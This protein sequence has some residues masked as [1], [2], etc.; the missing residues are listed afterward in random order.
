MND[1][2]FDD[3]ATTREEIL[4]ATYR[5][6]RRHGYADLT[7]QKIG[8]ELE[9]SPSLIY[10]HY[11]DK[12][13]LV[14]ACLEY[15]LDHFEDELGRGS[16]EDPR[17]RLE[18]LLDWGFGSA[19]SDEWQAFMQTVL[20]LRV[21]AIHDAAYREHFTR[22]DRVFTES[23]A[24][25]IRAGVASGEFR[26][27]DPAA[28]AEMLQLLYF[29]R[30]LRLASTADDLEEWAADVQLEIQKYLETRVYA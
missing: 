4:A 28:V 1:D 30:A 29:G 19:M 3:P 8:D 6:L 27:C 26:D 18:G 10:H 21:Q 25:I 12:D 7:I 16:I 5:S 11:E 24:S 2:I 20:E 14:L 17:E 22:S 15:L 13:A 9:Q 23:I